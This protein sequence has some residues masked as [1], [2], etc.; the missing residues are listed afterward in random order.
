M[1][2][3]FDTET[4]G[5]F[6]DRLPVDHPDQ[7]YIVQLAAEL[8]DDSGEPVAGFSF[9]IDPGIGEGIDIPAQASNVHGIT[10][11]KAVAMGV[12]A[13]FA[14]S[15]FTHLYQRADTVC[16]HNI[17]F[18]RGVTEVAI[19]RHYG[20]VMPLRKPL[21]CTM[22]AATPIMNLPPTE[23]MRAAGFNKPKPPKLEECIRHFFNED[24]DGAHDAMIDVA[25]CRRVYFHLKT[26]EA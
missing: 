8:C 21:F 7:P 22:E 18:D 10:N 24:L 14:L 9:I 19:A 12:S 4:T 6:Q 13:E 20:R 5:F 3:F 1:I 11:E 15:A 2:L 23:R 25:A 26:L 16:A 17:K